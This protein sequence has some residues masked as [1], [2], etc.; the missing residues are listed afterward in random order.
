[1]FNDN[2]GISFGEFTAEMMGTAKKV[3]VEKAKT[4]IIGA[5][6]A[7]SRRI[8]EQ[9]LTDRCAADGSGFRGR[10]EGSAMRPAGKR[11]PLP[12]VTARVTAAILDDLLKG[13][14]SSEALLAMKQE[15]VAETYG[16][17]SRDTAVKARKAALS[18]FARVSHRK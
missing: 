9:N 6:G 13:C 10:G 8:A 14:V 2:L 16:D 15:T 18:E 7:T 11:G 5:R 4:R 1:V 3:I 17:V 12:L